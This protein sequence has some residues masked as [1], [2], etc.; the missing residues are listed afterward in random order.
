MTLDPDDL[1][2]ME[3]AMHISKCFPGGTPYERYARKH[4]EDHERDARML[5]AALHNAGYTLTS[6][7]A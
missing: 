1:R 3:R 5:L 4:R 6:K 7:E 2:V